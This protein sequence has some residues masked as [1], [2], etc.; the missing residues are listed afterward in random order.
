MNPHCLLSIISIIIHYY[1]IG[2]QW[3]QDRA[4]IRTCPLHM[5]RVAE[6]LNML[7]VWLISVLWQKRFH[8]GQSYDSDLS[9]AHA[10]SCWVFEHVISMAHIS[11]VTEKIPHR[12]EFSCIPYI[13]KLQS[14]NVSYLWD[15]V[16]SI[17]AV[18]K[19]RYLSWVYG[20]DRKSVT[21]V[22]DRHH[23]A[24]R[25][26]PNSDPEWQIFLSTPNNHDRYFFLHT[27][28]FA[29][30]DF[31]RRTCYKVTLFSVKEFLLKF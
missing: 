16:W 27:F 10:Q 15:R 30:F 4:T 26:M 17:L 6:S 18:L 25:V 23:E 1:C 7:L 29:T 8:I 2:N 28:W 21:R 31:Q 5:R 13:K 12:P 9:T 24:C 11:L 14:R 22:T 3:I 19:Y 20:S